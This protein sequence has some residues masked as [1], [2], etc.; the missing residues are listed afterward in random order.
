MG[1]ESWTPVVSRKSGAAHGH[2]PLHRESLPESEIAQKEA[3]P[4]GGE[5]EHRFSMTCFSIWTHHVQRSNP[6]TFS[7]V[8]Q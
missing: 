7:Y 2:F 3:S 4:G 6:E 5:T 8:N 1:L